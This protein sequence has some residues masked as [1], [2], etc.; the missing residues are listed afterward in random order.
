MSITLQRDIYNLRAPRIFI[1]QVEPPD[2]N[3]LAA[4]KYSCL[5]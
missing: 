2:P 5:Y 4:I 3:P 1:N